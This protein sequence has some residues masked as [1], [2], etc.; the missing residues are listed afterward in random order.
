MPPLITLAGIDEAIAHLAFNQETLKAKVLAAIRGRIVGPDG[1]PSLQE[2]AVE[3]LIDEVWGKEGELTDVKARRKSF[4]SLKSAINKGLKDLSSQGLNPEGIV[5]GR[6]NVFEISDEQKSALLAQLGV[7]GGQPNSRLAEMFATFKKVFPEIATEHGADGLTELFEALEQAKGLIDALQGRLRAKDEQIAALEETIGRTVAEQAGKGAKEGGEECPHLERVEEVGDEFEVVEIEEGG[8]PQ[9]GEETGGGLAEGDEGEG[10]GDADGL[11]AM[12][13]S[14]LVEEIEEFAGV[15]VADGAV[16]GEELGFD[17]AAGDGVGPMEESALLDEFK[18]IEVEAEDAPLDSATAGEEPVLEAGGADGLEA[19]DETELREEFAEVEVEDGAVSGE[20]LGSGTAVENGVEPMEATEL[21]DEF[22]EVEVEEGDAPLDGIGAGEELGSGAGVADGVEAIDETELH[23]EFVEVGVEEG[24][25]AGEGQGAGAGAEE[26]AAHRDETEM[27]EEFAEVEDGAVSGEELGSGT[28]V[29]DGVEPMEATELLDEFEEVE[30]EEGDAPLDGTGAGEELGL[31]EG[32]ADG[33]EAIDETE[34]QEEFVEVEVEEGAVSGE[35]L[36]PGTAAE[37]GVEPMEATDL[38]DEFEEVEVEEGDAPLDGTGGGEELGLGAGG[39][40][41]LE[42]IDETELQ[43]EFVEVEVEEGAVAG[44]GQ[45]AGVADD[46]EAMDETELLDE[47][48]EVEVE[49]GAAAQDGEGAGDELGAGTGAGDGPEL[50]E[51][52]GLL[53]ECEEVEEVEEQEFE[54]VADDSLGSDSQ[55]KLLE[56]LSK[57]LDS[58]E[59]RQ[60]EAGT[61]AES[62]EGVVLQLLERFT[63]KFVKVPAGRYPFG[64]PNPSAHEHPEQAIMVRAFYVG[65]YPVTNDLFELFVRET[66][67]ETDAE[68]EG[69][70]LVFESRW[71][72]GKD[73]TT[74][75]ATFTI[76]SR[77]ASGGRSIPGANWRHPFGP[78]S[79]LDHKHNHPVVQVSRRDAQAFAAWAGKRLPSEAEWEAAAR[80]ADGRRF[81]WGQEW[82]AGR[83]NFSLSCLGD[84]TPVN[85]FQGLGTSPFAIHDLLGNVYEWTMPLEQGKGAGLFI[86]KGGCWNSNE[87]ISACHRKLEAESWSNIIGFRLAVSG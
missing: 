27:L 38:L 25:V 26:V 53:E 62:E 45:G 8:A 50:I 73:Q 75:L 86:L 20:E 14:E 81:P 7:G 15:E 22:E 79:F 69:Y 11:A 44:E 6:A 3:E 71:R 36:G 35:E 18:E 33:L 13:E 61:L 2:I 55:G 63:P 9:A 39:A 58:E 49:E 4:S 59:A 83:G 42:A 32:V 72:S 87:V 64:C 52:K 5:I 67:Y 12:D 21:L 74:G 29:E 1:A 34:L 65:Q 51:E 48:E 28:A 77:L 84:T 10:G 78:G 56:V 19:I 60:G 57:Y 40:D 17:A 24:A 23:E 85:R 46:L 30:V 70:G 47:F 82:D 41:G 31:G 68:R 54:E 43:E 37:G 80:G 16:S 76:C 66:G